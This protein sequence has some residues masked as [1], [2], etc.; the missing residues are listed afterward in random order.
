MRSSRLASI[1][2]AAGAVALAAL[3]CGGGGAA[4]PGGP[5]PLA[6]MTAGQGCSCST[7]LHSD[8]TNACD[9]QSVVASGTGYTGACCQG[10]QFCA[11]RPFECELADDLSFCVCGLAPTGQSQSTQVSDCGRTAPAGDGGAVICCKTS[12]ACSCGLSACDDPTEV[13]AGCSLA[14]V[15]ACQPGEPSVAACK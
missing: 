1:L 3:G 12:T 15:T 4:P 10:D 8:G 7:S 2:L 14:D 5:H 9:T 11:C 6:C 13:V